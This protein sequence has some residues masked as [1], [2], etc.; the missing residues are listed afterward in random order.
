MAQQRGAGLEAPDEMYVDAGYVSAS[1]LSEAKNEGRELIGPARAAGRS[2]NG[3]R[4]DAFDV[5]VEQRQAT[6]PANKLSTQCSRLEEKKSG[7]VSYR[8]EWST[9]CHGCELR[10]ACIGDGLRH[11]T[12][13]VGEHHTELQQ[14]RREQTTEAFKERMH[15]RNGIEGTHSELIRAHGLRQARYRGRKKTALQ[16]QF[17]GTACNIKRWLRLTAW[18]ISHRG[19][20]N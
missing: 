16:H 17:I 10:D 20:V 14:R 19:N 5:Q 11:R 6:C 15:Q 9:H 8:F 13:V 18:Q 2:G 3:Y 12:L 1:A 4:S 7:K